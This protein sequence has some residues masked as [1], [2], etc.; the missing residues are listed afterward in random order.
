M[1][2][3][4]LWCSLLISFGTLIAENFPFCCT[5]LNV[6]IYAYFLFLFLVGTISFWLPFLHLRLNRVFCFAFAHDF[7]ITFNF[8]T[9][10]FQSRKFWKYIEAF[11]LYL[12]LII[13]ALLQYW[14]C[15]VA[16][17][18]KIGYWICLCSLL[19]NL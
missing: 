5:C 12:L 14:Y 8:L 7:V 17:F 13:L 18:L 4:Y 1:F 2:Y 15:L 19:E 6:V 10:S 3:E 11:I 16:I 9:S